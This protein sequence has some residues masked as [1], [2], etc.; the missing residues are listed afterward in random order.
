MKNKKV[1]V[2]LILA[3]SIAIIVFALDLT[4]KYLVEYF[5]P[6]VGDSANFLPGF[7]GFVVVHN[8]GAGWNLLSGMPA[9]LIVLT[10]AILALLVTF[11][12]LQMKKYRNK[13]SKLLSIAFAFIV[14]GCLGNLYDRIFFGYVRDFL[15]FE[16][17]SFPVF[18]LA[19]TFL[20]I[21]VILFVIY[22]I[23]FYGRE[24]KKKG[25]AKE[26]EKNS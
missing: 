17:I 1:N 11:Y 5:L 13:T 24:D 12:A 18:N 15:N 10:L 14:G 6:N 23:F 7:I 3:I 25:I 26:E 9:L 21:G 4:S 20:T 22:F 16:F 19:D 8:D 2:S